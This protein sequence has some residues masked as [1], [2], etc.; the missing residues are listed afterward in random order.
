MPAKMPTKE[1][2]MNGQLNFYAQRTFLGGSPAFAP[3]KTTFPSKSPPKH[4]SFQGESMGKK[5]FR[6]GG[7]AALDRRMMIRSGGF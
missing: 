7:L 3:A 5:E 1:F 6:T 2:F 4:V